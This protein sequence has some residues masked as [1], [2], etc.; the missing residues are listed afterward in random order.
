MKHMLS[1]LSAVIEEPLSWIKGGLIFLIGPINLQLAYLFLAIGID[2]IFGIQIAI[3]ER[4]FRWRILFSKLSTKLIVYG[5]WISMFHAFDMVSGLPD[6]AR[7]TVIVML[8]GLEIVSA[9]KNT[10]RLGHNRLADALEN[11]YFMLTKNQSQL[12]SSEQNNAVQQNIAPGDAL[13]AANSFYP[14]VEQG[15]GNANGSKT[16]KESGR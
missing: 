2:L 7:W 11:L 16:E 14:K 6:S 13:S 5:L 3:R 8:A 15:G 10:A 1:N 4:S 9:I 12:P